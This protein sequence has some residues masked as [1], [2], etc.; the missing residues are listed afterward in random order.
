[1]LAHIFRHVSRAQKRPASTSPGMTLATIVEE[2]TAVLVQAARDYAKAGGPDDAPV[3]ARL[4]YAERSII[5][6]LNRGLLGV[7]ASLDDIHGPDGMPLMERRY[8]LLLDQ[9]LCHLLPD[10]LAARADLV[11]LQT[12]GDAEAVR[13]AMVEE[14]AML[15]NWTA[16]AAQHEADHFVE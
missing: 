2:Y 11:A 3:G 4:L 8:H 5:D 10:L 15:R 13:Q 12:G 1:M 16:M 9:V 7:H 14:A 6:A